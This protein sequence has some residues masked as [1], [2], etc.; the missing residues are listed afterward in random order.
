MRFPLLTLLAAAALLV[1]TAVSAADA[2]R[3]NIVLLISDDDDYEHFGFMGDPVAHTPTLDRLAAAGTVFT[4]AH[5]P[6]PLCRPVLASMLSGKLPHQHGIY[7]NYLEQGGIG[8]D[9]IKLDPAGSLANRLKDAGYATYATAKYWEGDA[10]VMGFTHGTVSVTFAGFSGFV[11]HGQH[12]LFRFI[13]E[14]H[15]A[16]RPMF[17]WWAPLLPHTPHDPPPRY[18]DRFAER[19]IPIPPYYTGDPA[20]YVETLRKFYAMGSWF[21]AG[22]AELIDKLE[23]SGELEN[24]L[25]LFFVDN[26]YAYGL[27]SKNT[28]TEKGLRTPMI[29]SWPGRVPAGKRVDGLAYALDLYATVLDYAGID[30]PRDIA[31]RSLRPRIEKRSAKGPRAL[32]GAV[33][34]HAPASWPGDPEVPRGPERDVYALYVRTERW[35]YV[36]YTQDVAADDDAYIWMVHHFAEGIGRARGDED[37]YDLAADPY[38]LTDLAGQPGHAKRLAKFRKQ[39]LAWWRETGGKPLALPGR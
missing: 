19:E 17:I 23:Q 6:A 13:D 27:P 29:A 2:E 7:A 4:T 22:V 35:K 26:G 10:R 38:E 33:F 31:S 1:P 8:R 18:Y 12:E 9:T 32:H 21:D 28:P 37:L 15:E 20:P 11:R 14:Q 36:L 3:P 16:G 30:P 24:T 5:V 34:A 25:F 39:V